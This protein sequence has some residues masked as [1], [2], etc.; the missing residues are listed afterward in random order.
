MFLLCIAGDLPSAQQP[1]SGRESPSQCTWSWLYVIPVLYLYHTVSVASQ[2]DCG[3]WTL[4]PDDGSRLGSYKVRRSGGPSWKGLWRH[5]S[6]TEE[7]LHWAHGRKARCISQAL[8]NLWAAMI[9]FWTLGSASSRNTKRLL[10]STWA[11]FWGENMKLGAPH[12]TLN[13]LCLWC[14]PWL[15]TGMH[16]IY[17]LAHQQ[18]PGTRKIRHSY[19]K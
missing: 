4:T 14:L 10:P 1:E 6:T 18:L 9:T 19:L 13:V 11:L 17:I 15:T 7:L 16:L 12:V 5:P 3:T 8:I 2:S